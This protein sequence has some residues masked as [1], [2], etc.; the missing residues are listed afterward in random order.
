MPV[1]SP[2]GCSLLPMQRGRRGP[3]EKTTM[4]AGWGPNRKPLHNTTGPADP[5]LPVHHG[6]A[7]QLGPAIS[8]FID[9]RDIP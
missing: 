7:E 5:V 6:Q 4:L 8:R 2:A 1:T 9:T 3:R